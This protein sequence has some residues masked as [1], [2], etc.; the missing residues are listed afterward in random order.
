VTIQAYLDIRRNADGVVRRHPSTWEW[1]ADG[2]G[3]PDY[4]WRDGNYGC[5]CNR[6][7][8]FIRCFGNPAVYEHTGCGET[9]Y[10]V[11]LTAAGSGTVLYQDGE[12]WPD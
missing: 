10:S 7:L 11:R 1:D 9:R 5:D 3:S 2:E 4:I 6:H 8:F 12:P